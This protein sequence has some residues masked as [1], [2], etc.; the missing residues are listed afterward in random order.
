MCP[1]AGTAARTEPAGTRCRLQG[2]GSYSEQWAAA[3][4][5]GCSQCSKTWCAY[6]QASPIGHGF[7]CMRSRQGSSQKSKLSF[8]RLQT[9]LASP[10][11][12]R[13]QLPQHPSHAQLRNKACLLRWMSSCAEQLQELPAPPPH[14]LGQRA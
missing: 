9:S 13:P 8:A 4:R 7:F 3:H 14:H 12:V 5:E 10:Q 1:V 11:A 2:Q 6:M